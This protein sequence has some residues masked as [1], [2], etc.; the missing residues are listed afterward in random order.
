VVSSLSCCTSHEADPITH[1]TKKDTHD[2]VTAPANFAT[3][4][5]LSFYGRVF[6]RRAEL[7]YSTFGAATWQRAIP[8]AT[9]QNPAKEQNKETFESGIVG[10]HLA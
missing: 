4:L 5:T 10:F 3:S 7:T 1:Q 9:T 2:F 6:L 8:G